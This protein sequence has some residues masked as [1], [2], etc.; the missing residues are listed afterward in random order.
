MKRVIPIIETKLIPPIVKRNVIHRQKLMRKML[1]MAKYPLTIIHAGAGYGKSTALSL[2]MNNFQN[3]HCWYTIDTN[4]DDIIPFITHIVYAIKK[5][6]E[7][8]GEELLAYMNNLTS[9]IRE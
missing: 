5:R 4:D 6:Y 2:F 1:N 8:F 3:N 7:Q 9:Y